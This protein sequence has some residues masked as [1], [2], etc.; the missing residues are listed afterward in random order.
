MFKFFIDRPILAASLSTLIV[1]L[2]LI[3]LKSLPLANYPRV[4]PPSIAVSCYYPGA[5]AATVS[6]SVAAV[7]ERQI[8]GAEGML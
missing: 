2:G 8:N 5:D 6:E 3:N 4:A 7:L 1:V